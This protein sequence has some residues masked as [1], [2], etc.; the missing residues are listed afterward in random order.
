MRARH[1]RSTSSGLRGELSARGDPAGSPG[2]RTF[3]SFARFLDDRRAHER[4][5]G[6]R[7]GHR[8]GRGCHSPTVQRYFD[9]LVGTLIGSWLPAWKPRRKVRR[10][11]TRSS[12]SSTRASCA[13]LGRRCADRSRAP[14]ADIS[15]RRWCFHELRAGIAY[16]GVGRRA[17][18]LGH[19]VTERARLRLDARC[20]GRRHRGEV[21]EGMAPRAWPRAR[22]AHRRGGHPERL[23]GLPRTRAAARRQDRGAPTFEHFSRRL[24]EGPCFPS[25]AFRRLGCHPGGPEANL[26]AATETLRETMTHVPET[27]RV[28]ARVFRSIGPGRWRRSRHRSNAVYS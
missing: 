21:L 3:D 9:T 8:P 12:T 23:R 25:P 15:S 6:Q 2:E 13:L 5:S 20:E 14:S 18:L 4:S 11:R 7:R 26:G 19:A 10:W 24:H 16:S 28:P 1:T 27:R 22:R 17:L